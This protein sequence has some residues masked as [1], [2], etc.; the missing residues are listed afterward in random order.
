[1]HIYIAAQTAVT[2]PK[3]WKKP[4]ERT[5]ATE[6]LTEAETEVRGNQ[7]PALHKLKDSVPLLKLYFRDVASSGIQGRVLGR[8]SGI[9]QH[10]LG[11]RCQSAPF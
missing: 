8:S 7:S 11:N 6:E 2:A 3:T 1:M 4:K 9:P 10:P 5:Q